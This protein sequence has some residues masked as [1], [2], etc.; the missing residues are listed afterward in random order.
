MYIYHELTSPSKIIASF[1]SQ[2]K[3]FYKEQ[4]GLL[5]YGPGFAD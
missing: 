3:F 2:K 4:E 5:M 1:D